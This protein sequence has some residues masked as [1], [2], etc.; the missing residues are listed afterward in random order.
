MAMSNFEDHAN[1]L[2]GLPHA[3]GLFNSGSVLILVDNSFQFIVSSLATWDLPLGALN[4]SLLY[5]DT[6][7]STYIFSPNEPL[8]FLHHAMV[9]RIWTKVRHYAP[10]VHASPNI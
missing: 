1:I 5:C 6:N 4:N 3:Q 8:F 2:E 10:S 9:D 7:L